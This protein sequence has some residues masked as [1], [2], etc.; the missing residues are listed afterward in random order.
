MRAAKIYL[1]KTKRVI[2]RPINKLYPVEYN[3]DSNA[4]KNQMIMTLTGILNDLDEKQ[5]LLVK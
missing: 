3:D 1:G 4:K 5:P 2:Q